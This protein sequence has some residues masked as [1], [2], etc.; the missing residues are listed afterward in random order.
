MKIT[1][2][3]MK[4]DPSTEEVYVARPEK[5]SDWQKLKNMSG[6]DRL[7]YIWEYYKAP[8]VVVACIALT[9]VVLGS[10]LYESTFD[11][12]LYCMCINSYTKGEFDA[13]PLEQSIH[14]YLGLGEKETVT[15]ESGYFGFG[16]D[17]SETGYATMAKISAM[18]A[19][20]SLDILIAN[21]EAIAYYAEG[22]GLLD[23]TT[24]LSPEV[25]SL[26]K[27]HL[28]YT[29]GKNGDLAAYAIDLSGTA[30]VT[31]A[32]L[33]QTPPLLSIL[34]NSKQIPNVEGL[35]RYIFEP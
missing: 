23:V 16:D 31:E 21:E 32:S 15:F 3:S 19:N 6:K 25:L 29:E 30:F 8:F 33:T 1:D 9:I 11:P 35:L 20:K 2:E 34:G 14:D 26:V 24:A 5:R 10:F 13:K 28:Y 22:D 12:A 18:T 27:D 17:A 7:W 4:P